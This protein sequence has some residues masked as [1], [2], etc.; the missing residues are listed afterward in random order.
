[1]VSVSYKPS[2]ISVRSNVFSPSEI[3]TVAPVT[4]GAGE[5]EK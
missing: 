1:M 5:F 3:V 2:D 4:L